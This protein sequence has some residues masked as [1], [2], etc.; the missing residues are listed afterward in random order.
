MPAVDT[1]AIAE[2]TDKGFRLT[3][4]A[5][6]ADAMPAAG[7]LVVPARPMLESVDSEALEGDGAVEPANPLRGP[8]TA[9]LKVDGGD[10]RR[11]APVVR[12]PVQPAPR[13]PNARAAPPSDAR[14]EISSSE[15][16]LASVSTAAAAI[17]ASRAELPAVIASDDDD[18]DGE[19]T[20]V[21]RPPPGV[22][23][24]QMAAPPPVPRRRTS[25]LPDAQPDGAVPS[26]A[27]PTSNSR[28]PSGRGVEDAAARAEIPRLGSESSH[29][30]SSSTNVLEGDF[31]R[32]LKAAASE[33]TN[34]HPSKLAAEP[35][36][37]HTGAEAVEAAT[38]ATALSSSFFPATSR[39]LS[40]SVLDAEEEEAGAAVADAEGAAQ[41]PPP[42][43]ATTPSFLPPKTATGGPEDAR[44][45]ALMETR[46]LPDVAALTPTPGYVFPDFGADAGRRPDTDLPTHDLSGEATGEATE[47]PTVEADAGRR[48]RARRI[49]GAVVAGCATLLV[50]A[51][52]VTVFG[53]HGDT[54]GA[55]RPAVTATVAA[56][57]PAPPAS[58]PASLATAAPAETAVL[59]R[60]DAPAEAPGSAEAAEASK[61][62]TTRVT[63]TRPATARPVTAPAAPRPAAPSA[64]P[65]SRS[66]K[67]SYDPLGI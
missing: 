11:P 29:D 36:S 14:I 48:R 52:A 26:S 46:S 38:V 32:A 24:A 19:K 64:R 4:P 33:P 51:L 6:P 47:L 54:A 65:A 59:S 50:A 39:A 61:R 5:A 40:M 49:V 57:T 45:E 28:R 16:E 9:R 17:A 12:A 58:S 23:A 18:E 35:R 21:G 2:G 13:A 22:L 25:R 44:A 53:A 60:P 42:P 41:L 62:S 31:I 37:I 3:P 34:A 7:Y 67:P 27:A 20:A 30:L 63:G 43:F 55:T 8:S 15:I 10:I 66:K 1:T 56:I